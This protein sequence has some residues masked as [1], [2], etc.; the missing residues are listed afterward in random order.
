MLRLNVAR[1]S[2]W[3]TGIGVAQMVSAIVN[4]TGEV[5][6]CC[7][8]VD[9][10]YGYKQT[11]IGLPVALGHEGIKKIIDLKLTP[12]EKKLLDESV[13]TVQKS[14]DFIKVG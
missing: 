14:V 12:E 6:P 1:T 10:E 7:A 11:S 8:V 9:G 4:D 2:G 13:A 3:L 5:I